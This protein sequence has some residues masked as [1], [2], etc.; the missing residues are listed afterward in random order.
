MKLQEALDRAFSIRPDSFPP[1]EKVA[2]INELDGQLFIETISTHENPEQIV[3]QKYDP[4]NLDS[5]LL[6]PFPYDKVYISYLKMRVSEA[7]GD[8]EEYNNAVYLFNNQMEE[9]KAYWNRT[10]RPILPYENKRTC[11]GGLYYVYPC[12]GPLEKRDQQ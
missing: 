10:H 6:I 8:S 7:Y 9:F 3:F 12:D 1:E 5:E 11:P 4:S 2:W